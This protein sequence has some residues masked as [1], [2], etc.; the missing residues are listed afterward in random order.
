MIP[1]AVLTVLAAGGNNVT[2]FISILTYCIFVGAAVL[3]RRKWGILFPFALSILGFAVSYLSPGTTI[4]G[5]DSSN[6]TPILL[7]IRKCFVWT[8]K[9]YLIRWTTLGILVM[10]LLLTPV[11]IRLMTQVVEKYHFRFPFPLLVLIGDVCFLSAMSCPSFYVLGEPG[12]GRLKNVIY[13]N[14]VI[15]VILT[16]A[17]LAGWAAERFGKSRVVRKISGFY[18]NMP[19]VAGT[20]CTL[21]TFVLLCAGNFQQCG[22]S[23]EAVKELVSGQASQY[24]TEAMDRKEMYLDSSLREVE[25]SPYSVKP[26]CYILMILRMN[27]K[28]GRISD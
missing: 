21:V 24:Y 16:Y 10:L 4:R 2:S 13:V 12:P 25:V 11:L 27:R 8:I 1:L 6:Y 9:Q 20:V 17:Y 19:G 3:I 5:G 26:I 15:I 18:E 28:T 14:F 23:V 22:T 7:T